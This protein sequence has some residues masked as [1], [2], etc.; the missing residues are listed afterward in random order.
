MSRCLHLFRSL[1]WGVGVRKK[2]KKGK[3]K[4]EKKLICNELPWCK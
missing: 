2:E 1:C 3:G 4:G